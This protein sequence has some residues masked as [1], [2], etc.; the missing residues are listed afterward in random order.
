[1]EIS[2]CSS[3]LADA[4]REGK[5]TEEYKK[6]ILQPDI[7]HK[8]LIIIPMNHGGTVG[9]WVVAGIFMQKKLIVI[10]DSLHNKNERDFNIILCFLKNVH[11]INSK[12]FRYPDWTLIAPTDIPRQIDGV[13]CGVYACINAFCL[14]NLKMFPVS[15]TNIN[16]LRH[17]I[18]CMADKCPQAKPLGMKRKSSLQLEKPVFTARNIERT[19]SVKNS[20]NTFESLRMIVMGSSKKGMKTDGDLMSEECSFKKEMDF[21]L[22]NET[23]DAESDDVIS[24]KERG[25]ISDGITK[26]RDDC[27]GGEAAQRKKGKLTAAFEKLAK[28]MEEFD[29]SSGSSDSEEDDQEQFETDEDTRRMFLDN[30][31]RNKAEIT[32]FLKFFW[33]LEDK[34]R[35]RSERLYS[36]STLNK[37]EYLRLA[38]KELEVFKDNHGPDTLYLYT[39][40][41]AKMF[42]MCDSDGDYLCYEGTWLKPI[43]PQFG[44]TT[45]EF[46]TS[47]VLQE[48]ITK[49]C[50]D[51]Y[52]CSYR[53]ATT[54]MFKGSPYHVPVLT[55]VSKTKTD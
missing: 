21:D 6:N 42:R 8:D 48:L 45:W 2:V 11:A 32:E 39:S 29:A 4:I 9:H 18:V 35:S 23:L 34:S 17:F 26:D 37:K 25:T 12:T 52:G 1:M 50:Q 14:V 49:A 24:E 13:N 7:L 43:G 51:I 30:F 38:R 5:S 40:H 41:V 28:T 3:H 44:L 20:S 46:F 36:L 22:L 31:D 10:L 19:L 27:V 54:K 33:S 55:Q 15:P 16:L 47:V 53:Q